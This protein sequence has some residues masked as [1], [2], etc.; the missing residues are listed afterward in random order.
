MAENCEGGEE[1]AAECC[2]DCMCK[3]ELP[4]RPDNPNRKAITEKDKEIIESWF[5]EAK[6]GMNMEKLPAFLSHLMND[7]EHDYGTICHALVAG[8]IA[9]C[10]A[11]DNDP[12]QGGIT[13]F[14]AGFVMWGFITRWM[15]KE[16]P[17]KLMEYHDMLYPQMENK[18]EKTVSPDTWK[19]LQDEARKLLEDKST[20]NFPP[21]PS[22]K[23]HWESIVA[24]NVPF[25][26]MVKNKD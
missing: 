26:Y 20:D 24:G 4:P 6:E 17:L 18:F 16:G 11:M 12:H 13:G 3:R 5:K 1:K 15:H 9:T 22:V 19:W 8:A 2:G 25:G 10:W 21:S 7:Y 14:Q 23:A